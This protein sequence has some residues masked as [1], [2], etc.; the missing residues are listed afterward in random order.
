MV[1]VKIVSD[2]YK[3]N[4]QFEKFDEKED[5]WKTISYHANENSKLISEKTSQSF[6]TFTIKE[7]LDTIIEEYDDGESI[8]II[9][10]G[11]DDEFQEIKYLIEDEEYNSIILSKGE[12]FLENAREI[13]PIITEIFGKTMGILPEGMKEDKDIIKFRESSSNSIPLIVLGNYS[14]G[15]STFINALIG[16]EV[17]PNSDSPLTANV[18]EITQSKNDDVCRLSFLI[19]SEKIKIEINQENY[20]VL[21]G[22][23]QIEELLKVIE[24]EY[25]KLVHPNQYQIL[26]TILEVINQFNIENN[27]FNLS[28]LISLEVPFNNG[29]LS[30]SKHDYVIFDTPGGNSSSNKNH[31]EILKNALRDM[32]NGLTIFVS[33]LDQLDAVDSENLYD[34]LHSIKEIDNRFSLIIVNKADSAS[35]TEM[36]IQQ[37]LQQSIPRNL[38]SEGIFFVSSI[39]GLGS[40]TGGHFF[41]SNYDRIYKKSLDEFQNSNSEYYQRLFQHNIVPTQLKAR[42]MSDSNESNFPLVYTNSGLLSVETEIETFA[43]KYSAYN[44]CQ[45]TN[46]Y[47]GKII[48][49]TKSA[50]NDLKKSTQTELE[51]LQDELEKNKSDLINQ[52]HHSREENDRNTE[53]EYFQ[54][55][56]KSREADTVKGNFKTFSSLCEN[57]YQKAKEDFQLIRYRELNDSKN[58]KLW[59]NVVNNIQGLPKDLSMSNLQSGWEQFQIDIKDQNKGSIDYRTQRNMA[60]SQVSKELIAYAKTS[61]HEEVHTK[62]HEI[63]KKSVIFWE[64]Q[65]HVLK[66]LLAKEVG[67]AEGLPLE[68]REDLQGLIF[69]YHIIKL[70]G[71]ESKI[72][73]KENFKELSIQI[74]DFQIF[75]DKN[76]INLKKLSEKYESSFKKEVSSLTNQIRDVHSES[77]AN[78]ANSLVSIIE[79]NIVD[80]SPDLQKTNKRIIEKNIQIEDYEMKLSQLKTYSQEVIS[81]LDWK[82]SN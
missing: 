59:D 65:S 19:N 42:N 27:A 21:V 49:K 36:D 4:I 68:K 53:N 43:S 39:M 64:E 13:L 56:R 8:S 48:D 78:W 15:K 54:I 40:K 70:A 66:N 71:D 3:K 51:N 6:L 75:G 80:F 20:R 38:Y 32:S 67:V 73:N 1:K 30:Q 7:V 55:L 29:I 52:L 57:Y 41:N 11:T 33:A 25:S 37:V 50:L 77:F 44:K 60:F 62:K 2:P 10:E 24:E 22:E 58:K 16:H 31:F 61:F 14:S 46:L 76:K 23:N 28:D 45:Q 18:F 69:N 63:F 35:L 79:S 81:L 12:Q 9:F 5:F 34:E 47:L 82:K 26:H 17:L 72:F 74:G